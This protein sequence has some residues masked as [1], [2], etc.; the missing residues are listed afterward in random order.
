MPLIAILIGLI[1]GLAVWGVLDQIQSRAVQKIFDRELRERLDLRARETL[2]RFNQYLTSYAATTRLL[3]NHRRLAQYLEP[4]FWFPEKHVEPIIYEGSRP[5]WLPDFFERNALLTPSHVLLIDTRGYVREIYQASTQNLPKELQHDVSHWLNETDDVKQLIIQIN[6]TPYLVVSDKIEDAGGYTMGNLVVIVPINAAFLTASEG[7]LSADNAIVAL[8]DA[9]KQQILISTEPQRLP[10]GTTIDN[11]HDSFLVTTQSLLGYEKSDWNLLFA[12]FIPQHSVNRMSQRV[13]QFERRQR[14]IAAV[15]FI[16]VFTLVIYL[17]STRLNRVLKR[18]SLFSQRALNIKHPGFRRGGNQL[19]LL[20][21]W[22]Q[23]FTHLVLKAREEMRRQHETEMRE[24]EALKAAIMEASLDSIVT[25]NRAGQVIDFN[26]MAEKILQ[27]D[28]VSILGTDFIAY[29]LAPSDQELFKELLRKSAH[30]HRHVHPAHARTELYA[31]RANGHIFPVE[32]SIVPIDLEA[33]RFYTLYIHDITKRKQTE[34]EIKGLARFVSESPHPILRVNNDGLIVYANVASEPLIH[35]WSTTVG[36]VLPPP[37]HDEVIVALADGVTR[38]REDDLGSHIYSLLFV[39]IQD[40]SYVNIYAR[41]ITAVRRAEQESRQHQ[42][43]LVHVCRLSTM[44]EVATGMAH[45][46]NQPLSAIA[47]YANGCIRRLQSGSGETTSLIEAMKHIANQAQR[48]SEIIRRL[49][50]LVGKQPPIRS[51]VDLNYLVR[52]V[53]SFVEFETGRLAMQ[54]QLDLA[55]GEI[56]VNVDLVQIEQV[57]LNLVRNALDALA[58]RP[59]GSRTLTIETVL[60]TLN[61][62]EICYAEVR[63]R[64]NGDGISPARMACLFD[65][66]F[67]TKNTG[68]GMGLPISQTIIENHDGRIWAESQLGQGATFYIRLPVVRHD[69]TLTTETSDSMTTST[70]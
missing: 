58:D 44:G 19:L 33:E 35:A 61:D 22:I 12:T 52:E 68:M 7:T 13:V 23:H 42:A 11:W 65:P 69:K 21:E 62:D 8:V 31:C 2:L 47:N 43:E 18:M 9:G 30:H 26:P 50:T 1:A 49:R 64:D 63:V 55:T 17:V 5:F 39:P 51:E 70:P 15:V 28:S 25:I 3:A 4:L 16:T 24:T 40:L 41:D 27:F 66:F 53:C 45:E 38:E 20:E 54:I 32:L 34:R 6:Y 60:N 48:A 59:E 10:T 56:P 67:T 37:W 46:I 57:L 36:A 14:V 29:F